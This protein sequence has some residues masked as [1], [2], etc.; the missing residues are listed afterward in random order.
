MVVSWPDLLDTVSGCQGCRLGGSRTHAVPGEGNPRARLMLIGEGPGR[1]EDLSGRPF[2]GAAGQLLEKILGAI[3]LARSDVYIANI[4]KCRPPG[5]RAPE[6]DEIAA[7][8]P[9]LRAQVALIRPQVIALLGATALKAIVGDAGRITRDRGHWIERKG[10]W[11]MPTFH[12]AALLRDEDKKR[13][14]WEDFKQ[15]RDKLTELRQHDAT[16]GDEPAVRGQ[17]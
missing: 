15:I 6:P 8:M 10:V 4:V 1:D 3:G 13:P 11:I 9:H 2:V 12:P 16:F 14:V 17:L 7:C 5:N